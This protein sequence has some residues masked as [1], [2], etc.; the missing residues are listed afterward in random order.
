LTADFLEG[1]SH[2]VPASHLTS[3]LMV[4]PSGC[5]N[6]CSCVSIL[7]RC[8]NACSC[9][10]ICFSTPACFWPVSSSSCC[11]V[12]SHCTCWF[13]ILCSLS[14]CNCVGKPYCF[15]SR[16]QSQRTKSLSIKQVLSMVPQHNDRCADK[17]KRDKTDFF[18]RTLCEMH[19]TCDCL[20][21]FNIHSLS[22]FIPRFQ[23]MYD[24][25]I[26][27]VHFACKLGCAGLRACLRNGLL[28]VKCW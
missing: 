5:C 17:L 26:V 12:C 11:N 20:S 13:L 6:P 23:C 15:C 21:Y 4:L 3:A 2:Q 25:S 18:F 8:C 27:C 14:C 16:F 10:L 19:G 1:E 22:L 28:Q 7:F 24:I 9:V